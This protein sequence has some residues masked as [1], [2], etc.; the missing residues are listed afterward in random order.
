[1]LGPT[2]PVGS[3]AQR[4]V[5]QCTS[6]RRLVHPLPGG[7]PTRDSQHRSDVRDHYP[8]VSVVV[9]TYREKKNIAELIS[10]VRAVADLHRLELEMIIVDDASDDGTADAVAG[11]GEHHWIRLI[12]R[13]G[14]RSLSRSVVDGLR[15][16]SG[17]YLV[18]MDADL[19]HP[20]TA[21]PRLVA[22][23]Q[24]GDSDFVLGSRFVEGASIDEAWSVFRRFNSLAARFLA[25]PLVTVA[26]STSGFFA[27][28]R[29]RF[30]RAAPLEPIGYK[31]GLELMVKCG[32]RS[33]TEIPIRFR[34][35]VNGTT[36]MGWRQQFEYLVHVGKLAHFRWSARS[37]QAH[38]QSVREIEGFAVTER[39]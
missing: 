19:S 6:F 33:I 2:P 27:L 37:R 31:I 4:C 17:R 21:I 38:S 36:K 30:D 25:R 22:G 15:A 18:V 14:P 10:Q 11:L 13:T 39:S 26:D 1:M 23:L 32:C 34:D 3:A 9:P 7:I 24:D 28:S 29:E 8:T 5:E 20:P 16:A 35:R 12:R